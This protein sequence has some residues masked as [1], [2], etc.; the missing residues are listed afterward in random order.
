MKIPSGYS[1]FSSGPVFDITSKDRTLSPM[2]GC[3]AI[4]DSP[5]QNSSFGSPYQIP[6]TDESDFDKLKHKLANKPGVTNPAALAATIGR[7]E[8]GQEEMTR[9]SVEGREK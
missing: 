3:S 7:R 1:A 5:I 2:S 8:L 4:S 6:V 9:R